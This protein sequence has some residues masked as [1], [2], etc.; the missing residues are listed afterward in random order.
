MVS[1]V[2]TPSGGVLNADDTNVGFVFRARCVLSAGSNGKLQVTFTARS[3]IGLQANHCS[4]GLS[5]SST[6]SVTT[7]TPVELTFGGVS[8]FNIA[9]GA[10]ITSDLI[11]HSAVFTVGA[12]GAV[13]V[14]IDVCSTAGGERYRSSNSNVD[15]YYVAYGTGLWNIADPA[16]VGQTMTT[17]SGTDYTVEKIETNAAASGTPSFGSISSAPISALSFGAGTISAVASFSGAGSF[18]A[19]GSAKSNATLAAVGAG[20]LTAIGASTAR[21]LLSSVGAGAFAPVGAS[22][23]TASFVFAGHGVFN[24]KAVP[25]PSPARTVVLPFVS[26]SLALTR[27]SRTVEPLAFYRSVSVTRLSRTI[28]AA[29][30]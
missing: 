26:R 16:S 1:T 30:A 28:T 20:V 7:T 3:N 14:D 17:L 6:S 21:G 18:A 12:G 4:V 23:A 22:T 11:D 19:A 2:F 24:V 27:E 8:G 13:I 29:A 9:A 5:S 25:A 15:T 10:S